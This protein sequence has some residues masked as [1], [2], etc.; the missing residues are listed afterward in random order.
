MVLDTKWLSE[1]E[2]LSDYAFVF[3][4]SEDCR[5]ALYCSGMWWE[6]TLGQIQ[7]H[8]RDLTGLLYWGALKLGMAWEVEQGMMGERLIHLYAKA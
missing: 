5:S 6:W 4:T 7:L 3:S 1:L 8:T 2:A